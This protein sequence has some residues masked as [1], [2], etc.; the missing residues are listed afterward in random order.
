[1]GTGLILVTGSSGFIGNRFVEYCLEKGLPVM[2]IDKNPPRAEHAPY[3]IPCDMTDQDQ[4][5]RVLLE[6]RPTH[7]VNFAARTDLDGES[8]AAYPANSL[9]VQNLVQAIRQTPSVERCIFISS[10]LVCRVGYIP[11]DDLDYCPPNVYGESK[12]LTEK[13]VRDGDGGGATWCLLRPTTIWGAGM[14]AHYASF[15]NHLK[16]GRYFH[17]GSSRLMKSYGYVGNS[18]FQVEKF[19]TAPAESVHRR[20]FYLADYDLLSLRQWI[21]TLAI[22][23]GGKSPFTMPLP[24]CRIA[25]RL[26]D[27]LQGTPLERRFPFNSFRLK[28]ILTEYQ[29]DPAATRAVCGELPFSVADGIQDLLGWINK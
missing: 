3:H 10:Q 20:V 29:F 1:M 26:G 25:A 11:K 7:I 24:I 18:V 21:D 27:L 14:N 16:H 12:V 22:G 8:V 5:T 17:M 9:G 13:A 15:F 23:M 28:N 19:L 6:S 4:L 2:G